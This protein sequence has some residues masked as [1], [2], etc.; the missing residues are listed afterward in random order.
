MTQNEN[1]DASAGPTTFLCSAVR[2]MGAA[3]R[4]R[5]TLDW[6]SCCEICSSLRDVTRWSL[7]RGS[8]R[9]TYVLDSPVLWNPAISHRS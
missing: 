9:V 6:V 7:D 1:H 8:M 4:L 5:A 3:E 2:D